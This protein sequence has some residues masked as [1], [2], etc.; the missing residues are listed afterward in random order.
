MEHVRRHLWIMSGVFDEVA[1]EE[2][3]CVHTCVRVGLGRGVMKIIIVFGA[4]RM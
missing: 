3:V 4:V 2:C 1:C